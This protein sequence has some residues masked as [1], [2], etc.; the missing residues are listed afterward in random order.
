MAYLHAAW[1]EVPTAG[2]KLSSLLLMGGS[3][4]GFFF[5]SYFEGGED[6]LDPEGFGELDR[7]GRKDV[8]PVHTVNM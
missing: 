4:L 7:A 5:G 2:A 6:L 1:T 8:F 3:R